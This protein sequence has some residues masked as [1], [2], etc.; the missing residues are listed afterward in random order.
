[1]TRFGAN[2]EKT[3]LFDFSIIFS[4]RVHEKN[5]ERLRTSYFFD[6]NQ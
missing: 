6:N 4:N 3:F 5:I 2:T 1:M